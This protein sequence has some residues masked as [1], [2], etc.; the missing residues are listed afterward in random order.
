MASM[1]ERSSSN[2]CQVESATDDA[3]EGSRIWW[4]RRLTNAN[5]VSGAIS[6]P[7]EWGLSHQ[8]SW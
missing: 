2:S 3:N 8:K 5:D 1:A 4:L 6:E 7:A